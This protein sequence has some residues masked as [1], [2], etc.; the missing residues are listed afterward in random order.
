ML[1]QE[2]LGQLQLHHLFSTSA[3]LPTNFIKTLWKKS[4]PVFPFPLRSASVPITSYM[5]AHLTNQNSV[6]LYCAVMCKKQI[7]A[8]CD[9]H[10]W[11][12][13]YL[14][15]YSVFAQA[16]L[17][18]RMEYCILTLNNRSF[19]MLVVYS[20][21]LDVLLKSHSGINMLHVLFTC[22]LRKFPV[23]LQKHQCSQMVS[24]LT[25]CTT[26]LF[27]SCLQFTCCQQIHKEGHCEWCCGQLT[28]AS[29]SRCTNCF[30][31]SERPLLGV[32]GGQDISITSRKA[33]HLSHASRFTWS[34]FFLCLVLLSC[35]YWVPCLTVVC[36]QYSHKRSVY[37]DRAVCTWRHFSH[38]FF[39]L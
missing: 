23:W 26:A 8:F 29:F 36:H 30:P 37:N 17:A 6:C 9:S 39:S 3:I 34:F 10:C 13:F 25:M 1:V 31:K 11:F 7:K 19:Q 22:V 32:I 24:W 5:D 14:M 16:V 2:Q 15:R 38:R 33:S 4:H 18:D 20:L 27:S 35:T 12:H 21:E 28:W